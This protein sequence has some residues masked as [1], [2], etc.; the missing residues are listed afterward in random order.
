MEKYQGEF[1]ACDI[2]SMRNKFEV[3]IENDGSK[4]E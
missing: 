4:H 3:L 2:I 1:A